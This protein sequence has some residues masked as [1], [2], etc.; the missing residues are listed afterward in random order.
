METKTKTV[1]PW[2]F[3]SLNP[4]PGEKPKLQELALIPSCIPRA[5]VTEEVLSMQDHGFVGIAQL[6][7]TNG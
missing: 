3:K 5:Y 4:H 6:C 1:V 7:G 2:W